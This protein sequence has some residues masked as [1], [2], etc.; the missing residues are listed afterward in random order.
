MKG[1][2]SF[3]NWSVD[4]WARATLPIAVLLLLLAPFIYRGI[5]PE[6]F[7]VFLLLPVYLV[8]QF[9]EHGRGEFKEF[10]N[11][12]VGKGRQVLDDEAIFWINMLGVWC[13]SLL[14]L[15]LSVYVSLAYGL[16][17]A[18]LTV[19][20]G[21]SHVVMAVMKRRPNPGFWTS[22]LLFLPFGGYALYALSVTAGAGFVPHAFGLGA[23]I[24]LHGAILL[25]VR[26][27]LGKTRAKTASMQNGRG[28]SKGSFKR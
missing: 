19:L 27:R 15:Y 23:A 12:V 1:Q 4:N 25:Y 21:V 6:A 8:H 14:G 24:V 9:E 3:Y 28:F 20:N 5:G 16:A 10:V 11:R 2:D 18:Y 22:L 17:V 7:F 13:L 26:D